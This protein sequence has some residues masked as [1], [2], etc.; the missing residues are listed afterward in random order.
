VAAA[1]TG[2]DDA[3]PGPPRAQPVVWVTPHTVTRE[4][5]R[6]SLRGELTGM[7]YPHIKLPHKKTPSRR[8]ARGSFNSL[9]L[10]RQC[11][12]SVRSEPSRPD[13]AR[14]VNDPGVV[15]VPARASE[16]LHASTLRKTAGGSRST[17]PAPRLGRSASFARAAK[18]R[19]TPDRRRF[20]GPGLPG[21]VAGPARRALT[22]WAC[23]MPNGLNLCADQAWGK[24]GKRP[25]VVSCNQ[26][27]LVVLA[28][29]SS[30]R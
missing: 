10:C 8:H 29:V 5:L 24:R 18:P 19:S 26:S 30:V 20:S 23:R 16:P 28:C 7:G 14:A 9:T 11:H 22:R 1:L 27:C 6:L 21:A 17:I 12:C 3:K 13:R 4:D 2:A 15:C 25:A